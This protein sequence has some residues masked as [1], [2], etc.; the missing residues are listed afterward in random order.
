MS[1]PEQAR[2]APDAVNRLVALLATEQDYTGLE[3]AETLWLSMKIE[4]VAT[5]SDD[6]AVPANPPPLPVIE[7]GATPPPPIEAPDLTMPPPEPRANLNLPSPQAGV[8]PSQTLPVWVADP[9]MLTNPLDII[10]ALRPLLKKF[11]IGGGSRID[12]VATADKIAR[13]QLWVPVLAPEQ[14]PYFD[15]VLVVDRSSSM[16]I[17]QRLIDDIVRI[18]KRYGLFWN[19]QVYDL[20][21]TPDA[22]KP[23]EAVSLISTPRRPGHR[24][25]ELID[26]Q[27]RRLVIVLSDC[28]APYWWQGTLLPILNAWGSI[29]PTT[30]WQM[31]PPWM[32]RRTALGQGTAAAFRSDRYGAANPQLI[33]HLQEYD[34][35]DALTI[36]QRLPLP[37]VTSD[38]ADLAQ[39]SRMVAGDRRK[40]VPGFL[41]PQQGGPIPRTSTYQELANQ[42]TPSNT[43]DPAAEQAA[44]Q[45]ALE[46]LARERVERFLELASPAAQRLIM[47]L[48]AAPVITLPV[49]RLI[50]DSMLPDI[51]SP[52]PV[53]EV[54]LSGLLQRLP[55]QSSTALMPVAEAGE[56]DQPSIAAPDLVQYDFAPRVRALLLEFLPPVDTIEVINSVSAAV[57]QRWNKVSTVDF[58][59]F[60]T[61]PTLPVPE[62]LQQAK[63]FAS[64]TADILDQLGPE[65]A[66]FAQTLR[67]GSQPPPSPE[68]GDF[69]PND[70]P[71]QDIEYEVAEFIAFP[72]LEPFEFTEAHFEEE[73]DEAPEEEV[74][75][76]PDL[77]PFEF[78]VVTL[79]QR[80]AQQ[81]RT[82]KQTQQTTE[83]EIHRQQQRAYR[84]V[85]TL[86]GDIPLE[87]VAIP[88]GTFAM[89]S[90]EDEPE[91]Y[92]D[93]SPQ[94][95]VTVAPFFMG[96]YPVTQW[97][98]QAVAQ[99]PQVERELNPDPS[100]FKGQDRPVEG[101]NWYDATEFCAR[102]SAHT[103][104]AYRLP[105]EAEWEYACRAD[106]TTPFHFG[107]MIT[108]EVANY[109]GSAYRNGPAG[110]SRGETTPVDHF[111]GAN[112]FGLSDMHGNVYEWCQ[113]HWHSDYKG[114][115]TDGSAWLSEDEGAR[116]IIRG[117]SWNNNPGYCRSAPRPL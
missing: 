111:E 75:P 88:G 13:T 6:A 102:L 22:P 23:E 12:E 100:R 50:R 105:T 83:W 16:H 80:P 58:R 4:A 115:P 11:A 94:H 41:L 116:R 53:A 107:D 74:S 27:G 99:L 14:R 117:G 34:D 110:D 38:V 9:P 57:E 93:E 24:P 52:L 61:D 35:P 15:V 21:V 98:W 29:M 17:W 48:A 43:E 65:Y 89:G 76:A 77:E 78:T 49:V 108:T 59:A 44:Q 45:Q 97:Q 33:T 70:F 20:V 32:W 90:P 63:S 84:W 28:A 106:T 86:P 10:R 114:A 73:V 26:Q 81:Q 67:R 54:F 104:R 3:I 103:G 30:V 18:L 19:V 46:D 62:G 91:R 8:L 25:R 7:A 87:M 113:D 68:P 51:A 96:R 66:E 95:E 37:V 36:P 72:P 112:A 31:L 64:I 55:G 71:L 47:L 5:V 39:W 60:L 1:N 109:N 79:R 56:A 40:V 2:A 82:R 69:D 85:E 92:E 101:V 42:R